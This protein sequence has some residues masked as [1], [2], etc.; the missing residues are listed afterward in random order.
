MVGWGLLIGYFGL[1][2][3][4]GRWIYRVCFLGFFYFKDLI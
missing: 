2:F 3:N 4:N 1:W